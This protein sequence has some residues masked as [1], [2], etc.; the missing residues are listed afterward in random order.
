M[1]PFGAA[2]PNYL[3][4]TLISSTFR[5]LLIENLGYLKKEEIGVDLTSGKSHKIIS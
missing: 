1:F 3:L 2:S 4:N 5:F